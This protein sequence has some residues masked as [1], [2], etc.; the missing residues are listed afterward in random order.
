MLILTIVLTATGAVKVE[1]ISLLFQS[2]ILLLI[3][4]SNSLVIVIFMMLPL[5]YSLN[6]MRYV[7]TL[8][9]PLSK[10]N[11]KPTCCTPKHTHL[12][13]N[14]PLAFSVVLDLFSVPIDT[15]FG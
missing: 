2:S 4:L 12:S 15:E 14:H 6:L 11:L 1:E 8:P 9:W 13:L 3:S 5:E 10:S 7:H